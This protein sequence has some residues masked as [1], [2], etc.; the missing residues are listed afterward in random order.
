MHDITFNLL[1]VL[2]YVIK[3]GQFDILDEKRYEA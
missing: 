1:R 2:Y 3:Y